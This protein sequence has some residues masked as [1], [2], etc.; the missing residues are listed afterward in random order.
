MSDVTALGHTCFVAM[1]QHFIDHGA[2]KNE[3]DLARMLLDLYR[4]VPTHPL[5]VFY[6]NEF[7]LKATAA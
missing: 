3:R 7:T 2:T 1:L 6:V 5:V 4:L